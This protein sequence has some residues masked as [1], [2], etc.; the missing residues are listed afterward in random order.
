MKNLLTNFDY[1]PDLLLLVI[2]FCLP[3]FPAGVQIGAVLYL[4]FWI[5]NK[6]YLKIRD[7]K[8][9]LFV[10][11]TGTYVLLQILSVFYSENIGEW[12]AD[13]EGK[14]PLLL[15]PILLSTRININKKAIGAILWAFTLGCLVLLGYLY[16]QR[17][18]GEGNIFRNTMNAKTSMN[19][20]YFSMYLVFILVIGWY[21]LLKE[22]FVLNLKT[23]LAIIF[24]LFIHHT[25]YAIAQRMAILSLFIIEIGGV[26]LWKFYSQRKWIQGGIW[27]IAVFMIH[28]LSLNF[29]QIAKTRAVQTFKGDVREYIWKA[30]W[31]QIPNSPIIGFGSG[32]AKATMIKGYEKTNFDLGLKR[33]YNCHSQYFEATISTGVIGFLA[34]M[35]WLLVVFRMGWGNENYLLCLFI[36]VIALNFLTESMLERQQ[37]T[38]FVA[39]FG[40]LLYHF[41]NKKDFKEAVD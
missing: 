15:L 37:G 19:S 39:L 3:L 24:L 38:Y 23:I 34:L 27:I 9:N 11:G 10:L 18:F 21:Y 40:G 26:I 14:I 20:I 2:A 32:D 41:N 28:T 35:I 8:R 4:L 36:A 1:K 12:S 30:T 17:Y 13:L 5:F 29:A 22:K 25:I 16:Y 31:S 7:I 33:K 6:E